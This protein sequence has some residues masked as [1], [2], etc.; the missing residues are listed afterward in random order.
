M[1]SSQANMFHESMQHYGPGIDCAKEIDKRAS[2][3][4]QLTTTIQNQIDVSMQDLWNSAMPTHERNLIQF[5]QEDVKHIIALLRILFND[6]KWTAGNEQKWKKSRQGAVQHPNAILSWALSGWD[7]NLLTYE[8]V[9][10]TLNHTIR[11]SVPRV[12]P[13]HIYR[14]LNVARIGLFEGSDLF[15]QFFNGEP[16]IKHEERNRF[17]SRIIYHIGFLWLRTSQT[18]ISRALCQRVGHT[19]C[20]MAAY[21]RFSQP[22]P[23]WC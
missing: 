13:E 21:M 14:I 4:A 20:L 17:Q 6:G 18:R 19:V 23:I 15:T 16:N 1:L 11:R 5:S 12:W 2:T 3:I 9:V 8:N 7:L 10:F 22:E